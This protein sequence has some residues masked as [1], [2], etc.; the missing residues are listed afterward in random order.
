MRATVVGL[1]IVITA[2]SIGLAQQCGE[3]PRNIDQSVKAELEGKVKL[4]S[5]HV[6]EAGLRG[7]LSLREMT[8]SASTQMRT[9]CV[10][11]LSCF[12]MPYP[13]TLNSPRKRRFS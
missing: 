7:R 8:F 13:R 3:A 9:E 10:T 6:G 4:L 12:A 11:M 2:P 1:A 5:G